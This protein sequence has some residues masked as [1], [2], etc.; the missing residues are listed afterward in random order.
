MSISIIC[1]DDGYDGGS[2]R[3]S[4][5]T[6][7]EVSSL[8]RD[9]EGVVVDLARTEHV[10]QPIASG[11]PLKA[12]AEHADQ[13]AFVSLADMLGERGALKQAL[14]IMRSAFEHTHLGMCMFDANGTLLLSNKQYARLY[15]LHESAVRPG[16]SRDQVALLEGKGARAECEHGGGQGLA[17]RRHGA[18]LIKPVR[19]RA[20]AIETRPIPGGG[21]I[22]THE[23]ISERLGIEA[24]LQQQAFQ[25]P[26]TSLPNRARFQQ[27]L[28]PSLEGDTCV[29]LLVIDLDGFKNVNCNYGHS[30][31]DAVLVEVSRRI[32]RTVESIG[33]VAR[34]DGDEFVVAL[35]DRSQA[36]DVAGKLLL[37][38]AEPIRFGTEWLS[39]TA[40]IGMASATEGGRAKQILRNAELALRSAKGLGGGAKAEFKPQMLEMQFARSNLVRDLRKA[41]SLGQL[42]VEYQPILT[43]SHLTTTGFEALLRW[44]HPV[45]GRINP[46]QFIPVA[47]EAGLI[48]EIGVWVLQEACRACATWPG[49]VSVSVN[50][51]AT[52]LRDTRIVNAVE[53]ALRDAS[54]PARRLQLEI[55]ETSLLQGDETTRSL[56][57]RLR[58]LGVALCM[59]DFGTGYSSL[60]YLHLFPFDKLKIDRSFLRNC[61]RDPSSWRVLEAIIGMT[62]LL[63]LPCIVEGIETEAQ[64]GR[65]RQ[66]GAG[67]VQGFLFSKSIKESEVLRWLEA[68]SGKLA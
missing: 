27:K 55:T 19:G 65:L 25:D 26:L 48:R 64:L 54:L 5:A 8:S 63:H 11:A 44:N 49:E 33:T 22:T 4:N 24:R 34:L 41:I 14:R 9:A 1:E 43:A 16:M 31:G 2:H 15:G 51:S 12:A 10:S 23:D 67:G 57:R 68:S 3:R 56:M 40:S 20:V 61:D 45:L 21:T 28:L 66:F 29:S 42:E 38:I 53:R 39:V 60:S 6:Y 46:D 13:P 17:T 58:E 37:S 50:L 32:A 47:E 35:D 62:H 18:A 36:H 7:W 59:D 30:A 52:E